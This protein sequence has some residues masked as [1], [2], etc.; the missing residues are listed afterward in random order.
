MKQIN[1]RGL[2]DETYYRLLS[3]A[4]KKKMSLPEYVR[5]ILRQYSIAPMLS[6][7]NDKYALLTD[8]VMQLAS[9]MD[10]TMNITNRYL[11]RLAQ[12]EEDKL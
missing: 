1:I 5:D 9:H 6:E 7:A 4:E 11:A 3:L 2:D 8:Q 10:E 12:I